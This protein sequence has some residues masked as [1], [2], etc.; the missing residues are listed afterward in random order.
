MVADTIKI[1]ITL[2]FSSG[3]NDMPPK[4]GEIFIDF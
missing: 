3:I 2:T 1:S 4:T